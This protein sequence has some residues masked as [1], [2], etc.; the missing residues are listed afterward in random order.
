MNTETISLWAL[1]P[2]PDVLLP[3][4]L[5]GFPIGFPLADLG[6]PMRVTLEPTQHTQCAAREPPPPQGC[7]GQL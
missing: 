7:P 2:F 6:L 3:K 4:T 5:H 1:K